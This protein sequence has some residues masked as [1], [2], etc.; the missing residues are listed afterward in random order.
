[1]SHILSYYLRFMLHKN[2]FIGIIIA[3][4]FSLF[5]FTTPQAKA[6]GEWCLTP[7]KTCVKGAGGPCAGSTYASEAECTAAK[8]ATTGGATAA[9]PAADTPAKTDTSYE[10]K[11]PDCTSLKN[12]LGEVKMLPIVF[13]NIIRALTGIM[14]SAALLVFVYGGVMWLISGGNAERVKAGTQAMIWAV[15][16]IIVVFSSYAII[17][18][19]LKA[20]GV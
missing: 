4:S 1:M 14:G 11:E 10:C 9:T 16:G 15:I 8:A 2:I 17:S 3:L 6:E 20:L 19:V 13:G 18:L 5:V 12:P 7:E